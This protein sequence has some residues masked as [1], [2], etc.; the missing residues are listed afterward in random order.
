MRLY[1]ERC[2]IY[3]WSLQSELFIQLFTTLMLRAFFL[4]MNGVTYS[5]KSMADFWETFHGILLF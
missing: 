1:I 2:Y 4:Y 3:N 5:L